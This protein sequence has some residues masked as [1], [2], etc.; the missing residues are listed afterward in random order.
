MTLHSSVPDDVPGLSL[1]HL[2]RAT[3]S[4]VVR[5]IMLGG[6]IQDRAAVPAFLERHSMEESWDY[7]IVEWMAASPLYTRRLQR[8]MNYEGTG[9]ST[10]YKG[11]QLDIG[12]AHQFMD[13]GYDLQD[14]SYGEFWL[15]S[16]GALLDVMP[17]GA[18]MT[19]GMCHTIEDPTFDATAV[20]TNARAQIRPLHRPPGFPKGGPHCHWTVQI[21]PDHP[22]AQQHPLLDVVA[23]SHLA[24]LPND[25]PPSAEPGGWEDYSG[26]FDP[27]FELE[28]LSHR[29]LALVG[30]E[31]S[32]QGHLLMRSGGLYNQEQF[33]TEEAARIAHA[34]VVGVARIESERLVGPLGARAD[35]AGIANVARLNH[36]L[37]LDDYLGLSVDVVDAD[38]VRIT[39]ADSPALDEGDSLSVGELLVAE[40][41]VEII[42]SVVQGVNPCARVERTGSGRRATYDVIVDAAAGPAKDD[43]MTAVARVSTGATIELVRRRPVRRASR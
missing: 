17:M 1:H 41:G 33:G 5:E 20:A 2:D 28:D 38:R 7:A 4:L 8:L 25:P 18:E 26:E 29:A 21:S 6:H 16:C 19:R 31:F 24:K 14:E 35:A 11:L 34:T 37:A 32:V 3:Q 42:E 9:V 12:F 10:I 13:V 40:R 22:E 27:G 30:R 39:V 36:F 15:R 23:A 43:P